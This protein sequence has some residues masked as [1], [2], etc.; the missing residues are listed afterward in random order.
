MSYMLGIV[1]YTFGMAF[2]L[3]KITKLDW[4]TCMVA[5]TPGGIQE[6]SLLADELGGDA[7]KV[8]LIQTCRLIFVILILPSVILWLI[9]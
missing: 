4:I 3:H 6:M 9:T 8:A 5:S 1:V 2:V 7:P